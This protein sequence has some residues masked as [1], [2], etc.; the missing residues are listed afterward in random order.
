[1]RIKPLPLQDIKIDG[2][3]W[4]RYMDLVRHEVIPYQWEALNDRVADAARSGC[5]QNFEI[6]AGKKQGQFY[7][8]CFQDSDLYKW[9][10]CVAYSLATLPDPKL[11]ALADNAIEL[12]GAA[13]SPDGYI[14]TYYTIK[15]PEGR[16][17]NLQ[18][19][20][21]LY[22]AGHLIEAAV[23]YHDA[24]GKTAF[25]DIAIRF[26]DCIDNIFGLSEGKINGYPGH[27]EIELALFKLYETTGEKRYLNLAAYFISERGKSP[28]Y[29]DIEESKPEYNEIFPELTTFGRDYSQAH[30]PPVEQRI[31]AGHSVRAVYM[32]A[33]MADLAVEFGDKALAT[34]CD[35]LYDDVTTKQMYITGAIGSAAAG[36][37]FTSAY[38][39]PNDL[40]YG[41]TCA[42]V[43]LMMFCRRMNILRG[44]ADYA[45]IMEL[46]LYNTVLAGMS[47]TG[48]EF[49]YVN[50]LE[51]EPKKIP[52][53]PN[54]KHIKQERPKWF[55]C[56]CC[57]SNLARTVMGLGLY[58]YAGTDAGLYVNLY[59]QGTAQDGERKVEVTTAYPFGNTATITVL[60]GQFCLHLRNPKYAPIKFL[61][62]D[63]KPEA[64]QTKDGY[65]VLN[66][67]FQGTKIELT[68]DMTPEY[69]YCAGELQYNTGKAAI[70]S[71]P[72]VYCAEEVD[73]GPLLAGYIL[74]DK[75]PISQANMPEGI[76]LADISA[77][78]VPA[79]KYKHSTGD[80]YH[81]EKPSLQPCSLHLI[82]YFL[83][84]NRGENEMRVFMQALQKF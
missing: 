21:E 73:N 58:A 43:G 71:G 78:T 79:Y 60:G 8:M 35:A 30:I 34:A 27:Q 44:K 7:G 26:A 81:K 32:Y 57:P 76:S 62:I 13:Q 6:A 29:F 37:R 67:N 59:C 63:G 83:W 65:I 1:M 24:T 18:H 54:Y 51:V 66:K 2:S 31:A 23:A 11:T 9:L 70:M 5:I 75:Q 56:A 20:H 10:E 69:V 39:L 36:E 80:L 82:P 53:N 17:T 28:N 42:S 4:N 64:I 38:D 74:D 45:D 16:W 52:L 84:A 3:F 50:P 15:E 19:G 12:I 49:F 22:C 72:I 47:L 68:F 48:K 40:I 33:A 14:N 46:A 77:L 41:E 61:T 55:D 25:L